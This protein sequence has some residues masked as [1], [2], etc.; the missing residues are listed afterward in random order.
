MIKSDRVKAEAAL[1]L[2]AMGL[3]DPGLQ[4]LKACIQGQEGLEEAFD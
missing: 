1:L 4:G 2:V 3:E